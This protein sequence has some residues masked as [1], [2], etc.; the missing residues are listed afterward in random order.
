MRGLH[1]SQ[2]AYHQPCRR[3]GHP[4]VWTVDWNV[5]CQSVG[6]AQASLEYLSRYVFKVAISEGRILRA[7]DTEVVF[8]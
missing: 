3:S 4:A 5:N 7:D 2:V 6:D 1:Q 8:R